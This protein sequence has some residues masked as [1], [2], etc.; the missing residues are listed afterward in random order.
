MDLLVMLYA[1]K[2][3]GDMYERLRIN[4][5]RYG[6][7]YELAAILKNTVDWFETHVG[8]GDVCMDHC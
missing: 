5:Q 2:D 3:E 8:E 7:S 4:H 6:Y 1:W